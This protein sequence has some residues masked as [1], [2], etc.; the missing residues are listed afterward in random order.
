VGETSEKKVGGELL[1][2]LCLELAQI[3]DDILIYF[4]PTSSP[5]VRAEQSS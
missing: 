1:D 2:L 4:C 3:S 5:N